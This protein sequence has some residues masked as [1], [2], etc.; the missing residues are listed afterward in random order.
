MVYAAER[1]NPEGTL[2]WRIMIFFLIRI[3]RR[4]SMII[5]SGMDTGRLNIKK[6]IMMSMRKHQCIIT[7]CIHHCLM[8]QMTAAGQNTI[9][10]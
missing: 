4:I 9:I 3:I 6:E 2:S 1:C 5:L 8:P 10:M 7:K